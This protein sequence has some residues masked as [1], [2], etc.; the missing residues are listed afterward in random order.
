MEMSTHM[1]HSAQ[2]DALFAPADAT[3]VAINNGDWTN[4]GTWQGGN[5]PGAGALV[6]IPDGTSVT[7]DADSSAELSMIRVDG[8]LSWSRDQ[9]TSLHVETLFTTHGS[10]LDIGT[11][12][13]PIP[14]HVTADITF[15]DGPLDLSNDPG[16]L[17]HG[18]VA[19][20]KVDIQG[21]A[22]DSHMTL[23]GG[24]DK[25][26]TSVSVDGNLSNW[27]VGDQ[28]LLVGTKYLGE[29]DNDVLQTQ[30]ETRIIT[31]VEG[32]T[33]TFDAPL[34]YDHQPPA[35]HDFDTYVANLSRNVTFQSENPEGVRGHIM[36]HNGTPDA[37]GSINNVRYAEFRDLG[38]TDHS[39]VV[40]DEPGEANPQG[41][42]SLHLHEIGTEPGSPQS[43]IEGNAVVGNPGWGIVQ[44]SS[45][46]TINENV[47]FDVTGAGIV[48][49]I[50]DETGSWTGNLVT[51]VTGSEVTKQ[52]GS[53]GAAYE[54]QSR[55]IIQQDN[56][57]ANSKIAWNFSGRETFAEDA[58]HTGAPRDG[59]HRKLFERE[60]LQFDPSPFDVAI[61]HEEPPLVDFNDN[62][63]V[64]TT[65]GLRVFHRQFSDD[66]DTMSVLD[67]FTVWGGAHAVDL[68][69]YA[70]NYLFKDSIWQGEGI[71]FR[72]ERKTSSAVFEDVEFV[73]FGL[74]YRSYG[75]NHE[76]VLI[77]TEFN[78]V[79]Q[80]FDIKDL[81]GT[82]TTESRKAELIKYFRDQHDIDYTNPL[83]TIVDSK[84]LTPVDAVTFT[85]HKDADLSLAPGDLNLNI[86]G[87]THDSVGTRRYNEYVVAKTPSGTGTS[88]DYD[89]LRIRLAGEESDSQREFTLDQF[90]GLHGTYQKAN[91]DWVSPVV[92]WITDRLTGDHHPVVIEIE[93]NGFSAAQMQKFELSEYPDPGINN[94]NFVHDIPVSVDDNTGHDGHTDG[95]ATDGGHTDGGATDGGHT[96]GGA[97]DGGH[98][99][100][101]ATDGGHTDGGSTDGGHTDGGATDGGHTDGGS[102]DGG[103]A[104]SGQTDQ[105]SGEDGHSGH[106]DG[107]A[108]GGSSGSGDSQDKTTSGL[109]QVIGTGG[110]DQLTA[111]NGPSLMLGL[112]DKDRLVGSE[113]NDILDGGRDTDTLFG[114]RGA[115]IFR[116]SSHDNSRDD[117]RDFSVAEGDVLDFTPLAE[118]YGLSP[119]EMMAALRFEQISIGVRISL[120][121]PE[122]V[123]N[124][125]TVYRTT[126]AELRAADAIIVDVADL[127]DG[128]YSVPAENPAPEDPIVEDTVQDDP[129]ETPV[130]PDP[131]PEPEAPVQTGDVLQGTSGDD[132]LIDGNGDTIVRGG[133]GKDTLK[134]NGGNDTLE[135]GAGVDQL[136]GGEGADMFVF[137]GEDRSP[138][139]IR[140]FS[141][142]QG[143]RIDISAFADKYG[144]S[145]SEAE[146]ALVV[147]DLNYGTKI[148]LQTPDRLQQITTVVR[149]FEDD[150]VF[151]D[152]FIV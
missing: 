82:I 28:I 11:A 13:D 106:D 129:I 48:S 140:D 9:D 63:A 108:T 95:G 150:I 91:G 102:T 1:H 55:V 25:G 26:A 128:S 3:H 80:T 111:V 58:E 124:I 119:D 84:D 51:S 123:Q 12:A 64:G 99:D 100:G 126:E 6:H 45:H 19:F 77:D 118:D 101:G 32:N 81:V 24:A 143:D 96:D 31:K 89:G 72:I 21:A 60:Q 90:L 83:P 112:G 92:N 109:T 69:N 8:A 136:Y 68:E 127:P 27:K 120:D 22:K 117:L 105:G 146:N 134:G 137:A 131:T 97:T 14:A 5:V 70:S 149:L 2:V 30:D 78:N 44:H 35:G 147:E 54:N 98:T 94:P 132:T 85:A 38:R 79:L 130:V 57:A 41:R 62:T 86:K 16:Q 49:E 103:S 110:R 107:G 20:G 17:T 40:G 76:V 34:Q 46:A 50:G 148:S 145:A 67:N 88:R 66:T 104:G 144:W 133:R 74:G 56:I 139:V 138:D 121:L 53:E 75:V 4:P 36:L 113:G 73:D 116:F 87:Y 33:I 141:I 42:Y 151:D 114:G 15:T 142:A 152:L 93:L 65:T 18:L 61:D 43:V 37:D 7:Y 71:G 59:I 52:I 29:D 47:V 23:N 115:D 122:R 10:R 39:K 125:A 135:G